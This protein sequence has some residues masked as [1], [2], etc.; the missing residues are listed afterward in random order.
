MANHY[1]A[2]QSEPKYG[3][4]VLIFLADGFNDMEF[5][6]PYY[7]LIEEGYQVTVAGLTQGD[8]FGKY[9]MKFPI[10]TLISEIDPANFDLLYVP[11]GNAPEILRKDQ[12]VLNVVKFF[13]EREKP[14]VSICHGPLVLLDA[15]V[16]SG[17]KCTGFPDIKEALEEG[18]AKYID[19]KVVRDVHLITSRFPGDLPA[20]M[21][22]TLGILKE[23]W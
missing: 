22:Q 2:E 12:D 23:A 1:V 19:N 8:C 15:G 6:Y 20:F 16:L 11:G 5:F 7:R 10:E 4:Q 17:K 14:I 9:Q 13:D 21:I 18:G 3:E